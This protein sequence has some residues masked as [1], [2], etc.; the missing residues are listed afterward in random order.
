LY[1]G[2]ETLLDSHIPLQCTEK[3]LNV[4]AF[5]I[6]CCS[7]YTFLAAFMLFQTL[8]KAKIEWCQ[9]MVVRKIRQHPVLGKLLLLLIICWVGSNRE[10]FVV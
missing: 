3:L 2:F 1:C 5:K 9:S 7:G 8:L 10:A 6:L 4:V